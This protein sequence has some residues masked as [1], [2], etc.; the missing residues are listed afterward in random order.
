MRASLVVPTLNEAGSIGHVLATFRAAADEA[1]RTVF[2]D[3]PVVWEM[4]VV[5][6]ASTDGTPARATAEG[7][8]VITERRRG[9]GR[10]YKTGFAAATG[11][12]VAT[13]DGDATYPVELI[14]GLVRRLLDERIDFLTGDRMAYL[15]HRSMTT[16]HRLGNRMLNDFLRL[17]YK[18]YLDEL[19]SS[20][21]HD[22]QSGFWVFRREILG[23]LRLTQDGMAFSEEFKIEALFRGLKVVEIPIHYGERWGLPKLSSWRDGL[24]NLLFLIRK[25][26]DVAHEER[27]G[28][29][30][31]R[32]GAAGGARVP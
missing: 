31:R 18:R 25:R 16:E 15:D 5:D 3:E 2:R 30:P 32:A 9:Y 13:A 17:A 26:L 7:A 21:L 23:R 27:R 20:T 12:I 11:E 8:R 6:G 14:P 19:P 29:F 22:S 10:A 1:N 4:I 28:S 24:Q